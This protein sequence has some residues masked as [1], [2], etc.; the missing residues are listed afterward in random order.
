MAG[1][2]RNL[3]QKSVQYVVLETQ[4]KDWLSILPYVKIKC[5]PGG[6]VSN[7]AYIDG[8]VFRK[9]IA[10]RAMNSKVESPR[11]LL[12]ENAPIY[13]P[14]QWTSFEALSFESIWQFKSKK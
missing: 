1:C 13:Q 2:D 7:C 12:L 8:L 9:M 4:E 6:T 5:I 3:V 14:S 11:I 10:H